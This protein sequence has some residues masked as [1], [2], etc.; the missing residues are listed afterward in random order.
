MAL[1][2]PAQTELLDP[3]LTTVRVHPRL[4]C[5]MEQIHT[6]IDCFSYLY[7]SS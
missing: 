1:V 7:T 2:S 5:R 4:A 6:I 3:D